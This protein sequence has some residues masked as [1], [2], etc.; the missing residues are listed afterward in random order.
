MP[1]FNYNQFKTIDLAVNTFYKFQ[2]YTQL[3]RIFSSNLIWWIKVQNIFKIF[4]FLKSLL[5][6]LP[7]YSSCAG[8]I[9]SLCREV[10]LRDFYFHLVS[11]AFV[12]EKNYLSSFSSNVGKVVKNTH[13]HTHTL[14][15][16]CTYRPKYWIQAQYMTCL[17]NC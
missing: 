17:K 15:H 7:N 6:E 11:S 12:K 4:F 5:I 16:S 9:W 14:Q 1:F 13:T 3:K 2:K 8:V 10:F